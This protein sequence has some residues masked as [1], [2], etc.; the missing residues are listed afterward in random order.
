MEL[1]LTQA[2][3][4]GMPSGLRE[5]LFG[6]LGSRPTDEYHTA[7]V[8]LLTREQAA[9][10]VRGISFH[11]AGAQLRVLLDRLAYTD[12]ARPPSRKRLTKALE[13]EGRQL[14]G[15]LDALNRLTANVTGH[16]GARLCEHQKTTDT[17]TVLVATREHLRELLSTM[18]ASGKVEESLWELHKSQRCAIA[19]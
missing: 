3:I 8:A 9:A 13:A 14:G 4:D 10:L 17:Y 19:P 7:E 1:V 5:Q 15:Y 2:A 18:R 12:T 11:H 6:Y 16:P